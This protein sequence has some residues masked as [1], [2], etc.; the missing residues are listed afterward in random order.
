MGFTQNK[1]TLPKRGAFDHGTTTKTTPCGRAGWP[2]A[3][4]AGAVAGP[5]PAQT[6]APDPQLG[7]FFVGL[8]RGGGA[9]D[10]AHPL[11][12]APGRGFAGGPAG[13]RKSVV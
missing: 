1:A 12:A 5:P 2:A 3:P 13:D 10:R 8:R 9:D 7:P 11:G 4:D 6:A